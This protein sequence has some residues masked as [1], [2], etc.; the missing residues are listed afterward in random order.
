[1]SHLG[2]VG[3]RGRGDPAQWDLPRAPDTEDT[4]PGSRSLP[5]GIPRPTPRPR[6]LDN[7]PGCS[8]RAPMVLWDHLS[9][10]SS[11]VREV[12]RGG[13]PGD[14]SGPSRLGCEARSSCAYRLP[15]GRYGSTLRA[16]RT[17]AGCSGASSTTPLSSG[18]HRP[19]R[20]QLELRAPARARRCSVLCS[21]APPPLGSLPTR[22]PAHGRGGP[23]GAPAPTPR[24]E[25]AGDAG[26]GGP[27]VGRNGL[28]GESGPCL[29]SIHGF[30]TS[31]V[32]RPLPLI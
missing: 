30:L 12:H 2:P 16:P 7:D 15:L 21:P 14:P 23:P 3:V 10:R 13:T 17:P 25:D 32:S 18:C 24:W 27:P 4:L 11:P 20:L 22:P 9:V 8:L 26:G 5:W 28:S 31:S 29:H 19:P 1:M 6:T